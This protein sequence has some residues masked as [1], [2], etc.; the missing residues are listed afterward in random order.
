MTHD[1]GKRL[2]L[3][4]L[5]RLLEYTEVQKIIMGSEKDYH[6]M[7]SNKYGWPTGQTYYFP[8]WCHETS[9]TFFFII[10]CSWIYGKDYHYTD[11]Q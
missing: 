2:A 10:V 5:S 3:N 4:I 1:N 6:Y 8:C 9:H 11:Q 7:I